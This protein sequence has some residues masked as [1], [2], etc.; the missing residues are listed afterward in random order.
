MKN[1]FED[2]RDG[3]TKEWNSGGL[4]MTYICER[5]LFF[6]GMQ[7]FSFS[8]GCSKLI[9]LDL[10]GCTGLTSDSILSLAQC[11]GNLQSIFLNDMKNLDDKCMQVSSCQTIEFLPLK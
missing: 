10:S 11:C 2:C 3:L 5:L 1:V 4:V 8:Q 9:Y 7:F 6:R